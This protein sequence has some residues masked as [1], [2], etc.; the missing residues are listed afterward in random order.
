MA[1]RPALLAAGLM[2]AAAVL[3]GLDAVIVRLLAG[4]VHPLVIGF[5]HV[6]FG[7]LAVLPWTLGRVDLRASP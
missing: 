5:F 4:Q 7:L 2:L 6:L 1:R 3:A